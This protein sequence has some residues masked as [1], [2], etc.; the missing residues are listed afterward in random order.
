MLKLG[1]NQMGFIDIRNF[2]SKLIFF[3]FSQV[4]NKGDKFTNYID[5]FT[6]DG[7]RGI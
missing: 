1:H 5:N 7:A 3:M 4:Y 6:K 2:E